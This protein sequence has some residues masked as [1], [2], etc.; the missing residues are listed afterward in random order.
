MRVGEPAEPAVEDPRS[1][2]ESNKLQD[3]VRKAI[4]TLPD[5]ERGMIEGSTLKV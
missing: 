1:P 3:S 4:A 5:A 2:L